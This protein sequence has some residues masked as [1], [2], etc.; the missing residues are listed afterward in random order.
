M[1]LDK[2]LKN[3]SLAK[4]KKEFWVVF[5]KYVRLRDKNI[6]FTCGKR[7]GE[8]ELSQG[9]HFIPRGAC[10]LAL[11]FHEDN[12]KCQC[13][14][15]NLTLQGNSYEFGKRLGEKKVAELNKIRLEKKDLIYSKMDY[16]N[17]IEEYKQKI[18]EL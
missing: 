2:K 4:W 18:K 15:C 5:S 17:L 1:R 12:V 16:H 6:C 10:G 13:S 9:G 11:Y 14:Y 8:G 7:I 3:W